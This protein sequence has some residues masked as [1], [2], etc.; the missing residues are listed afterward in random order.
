MPIH[1]TSHR[2]E[3]AAAILCACACLTSCT[4]APSALPTVPSPPPPAGDDRVSSVIWFTDGPQSRRLL[5]LIQRIERGDMQAWDAFIDEGK[6]VDGVYG[7]TYAMACGELATRDPTIFLRRHLM[8]DK[9]AL[10]LGK[11]A[12]GWAGTGGRHVMNWLN[13]ARLHLATDREEKRRIKE[14][15]RALQGELKTIEKKYW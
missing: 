14:Y 11:T 3:I 2:F 8:G 13:V 4:T 1:N 15:M 6:G 10:E 9:R 12:Y 5:A 7:E